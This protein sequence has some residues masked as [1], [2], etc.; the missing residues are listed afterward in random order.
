MK[1]IF[2]HLIGWKL[3]AVYCNNFTQLFL[4]SKISF[5]LLKDNLSVLLIFCFE[6][7]IDEKRNEII[8]SLSR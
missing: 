6:A 2:L 8:L 4:T 5:K 7:L 1:L 3:E